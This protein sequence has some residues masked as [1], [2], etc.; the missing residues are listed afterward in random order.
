[1]YYP[2]LFLLYRIRACLAAYLQWSANPIPNTRTPG[3]RLLNAPKSS[4]VREELLLM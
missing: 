4:W 3:V 2:V 1:M